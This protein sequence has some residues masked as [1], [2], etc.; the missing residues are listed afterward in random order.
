M[1]VGVCMCVCAMRVLVLCLLFLYCNKQNKSGPHFQLETNVLFF[2]VLEVRN[3]KS[4]A[5]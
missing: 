3:F 5:T 1:C 2:F 4:I